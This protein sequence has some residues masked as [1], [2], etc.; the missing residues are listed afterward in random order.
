MSTTFTITSDTSILSADFNPPIYLDDNKEYFLGLAD[1]ESFMSIP[2]IENGNNKLYVENS[3]ITIPEGT[4]DVVDLE[5]LIKKKLLVAFPLQPISFTLKTNLN[6]LKCHI[7]CSKQID[8]TKG[9][10]I[11]KLLGFIEKKIE[12]NTW[13]ESDNV[14]NISKVNAICIDCNICVGSFNNGK[15]VHI[16]HQFYPLVPPGYK[17]VESPLPIL[18]FPVSVK[19][20]NN[21]TIKIVDQNG[22]LINFRNETITVRLHLKTDKHGNQV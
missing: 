22:D 8:F 20:I 19:A 15:P 17:I 10:S 13:I 2:N 18:Y 5:T 6:T 4:Y 7:R 12:V 16:I 9:D 21:I 14:V 11:G 1:F 3:I